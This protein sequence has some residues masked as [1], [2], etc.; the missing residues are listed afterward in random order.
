MS[1]AQEDVDLTS[2]ADSHVF[3]CSTGVNATYAEVRKGVPQ[4][5]ISSAY[6]VSYYGQHDILH[7]SNPV[8]LSESVTDSYT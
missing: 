3:K 7:D 6:N 8:L 4:I 5:V 2:V 1:E